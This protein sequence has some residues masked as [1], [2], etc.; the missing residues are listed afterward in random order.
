MPNVTQKTQKALLWILMIAVISVAVGSAAALFLRLLDWVTALRMDYSA[1]YYLLP[2]WGIMIGWIY[3]KAKPVDGNGNQFIQAAYIDTKIIAPKKGIPFILTPIVLIGTLLTHLGGGAAGREGTAVQMGASIASQFNKWFNLNEAEQRLLIALGVSAGFAGVFGTPIAASVFAFEFF[4]FRKTK[5]YF[6][7]PSLLVAYAA[8][9]VCVQWGIQHAQYTINLFSDYSYATIG[10]VSIA[11]I[12]FGLAAFLFTQSSFLFTKLAQQIKSSLLR[13]AIG[14]VLIVAFVLLGGQE[15]MAGLGLPVI[16]DAFVHQQAPLDFLIKLLLTSFTLS[17][18]FKGGEVT[19][20]FF[21]GAVL[22]S[23]LVLLIP[24]PISLLA[25]LGLIGVF[26]GATHCVVTAIVLGIELFG[27]NFTIYIAIA[28]VI[29]Y[30]FAGNKSIYEG[31]P[32]GWVKKTIANYF[33]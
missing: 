26:A 6:I 17:V 32:K 9:F 4:G 27:V 10:W 20:L 1:F 21:I 28:C 12:F 11:G 19:P 24:L 3:I 18:G 29:A 2:I 14:G 16:A 25:G 15:K 22:G 30:L 33:L 8:D 5:W 7:F 31:R 23:A 13:P